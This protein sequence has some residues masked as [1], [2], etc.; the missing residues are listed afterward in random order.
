MIQIGV[1]HVEPLCEE[2]LRNSLMER[3]PEERRRKVRRTVSVRQKAAVLGAGLL[4]EHMLKGVLPETAE[5]LRIAEQAGG[6]P[7][8]RDHPEI[9]F[10]LSHSGS[11]AACALSR[12]P[13]GIDLQQF[14]PRKADI[15]ARHFTVEEQQY[16][17]E[18]ESEEAAFFQ[19]WALKESFLKAAGQ[20]LRL[21]LTSFS[22]Q[23]GEEIRITQDID[24]AAYRLHLFD[25]GIPYA[26]AL[27]GQEPEIGSVQVLEPAD[28][29]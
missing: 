3:V 2:A 4:L 18:A 12:L 15:A 6:K 17:R 13:V 10:N 1:L 8:L 27:C 23:I 7:Y 28:I 26:L 9:Y 20:G 19:I 25:L 24:P 16:I 11:Y 22:I 14:V 21:P 5:D 29:L